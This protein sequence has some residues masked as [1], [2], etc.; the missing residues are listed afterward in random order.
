MS[1]MV[2]GAIVDD[3]F[4][5][6]DFVEALAFFDSMYFMGAGMEMEKH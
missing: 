6:T 5:P 2:G 4:R 3:S 1:A